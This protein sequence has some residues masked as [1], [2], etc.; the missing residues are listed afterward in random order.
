MTD[1]IVHHLVVFTVSSPLHVHDGLHV[2]RLHFH[3][4]GYAHLPVHEFQFINE[5]TLC[6]ILH[7]HINRGHDVCSVNRCKDGDIEVFAEHLTTMHQTVG[8]T[9]FLVECQLQSV[10][11]TVNL[12]EKVS[13]GTSS[14]RCEGLTTGIVFL[15]VE[16]SFIDRFLEDRQFADLAERVIV[17]AS[18]PDGPVARAYRAVL[19]HLVFAFQQM[20]LEFCSTL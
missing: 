12:T 1:G 15:P 17:D 11:R 20:A 5:G 18:F 2:A 3:E 19:H 7:R 14:Q 10:F 16:T 8:T 9:E 4:D 13:D 6:Q